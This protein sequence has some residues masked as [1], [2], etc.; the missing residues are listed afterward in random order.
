MADYTQFLY[1]YD[2]G[3]IVIAAIMRV[4]YTLGGWPE[5]YY[6]IV[7][8]DYFNPYIEQPNGKVKRHVIPDSKIRKHSP[9]TFEIDGADY[10][11]DPDRQVR[12]NTGRPAWFYRWDDCRPLSFDPG[13][14]RCDP[15][16]VHKAIRSTVV[17][18][19]HRE[20]A[21]KKKRGGVWLAII[22]VSIIGLIGYYAWYLHDLQ[23]KAGHC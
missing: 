4:W 17:A 8:K 3:L 18:D 9:S 1:A 5:A 6:R 20:G 2:V 21:K 16:V 13:E 12:S 10:L 15:I 23:C 19:I 22:V 7:R 11:I 14:S